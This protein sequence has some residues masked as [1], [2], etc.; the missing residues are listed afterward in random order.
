MMSELRLELSEK[1]R[2]K[3]QGFGGEGYVTVRRLGAG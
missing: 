2:E 1:A 3:L